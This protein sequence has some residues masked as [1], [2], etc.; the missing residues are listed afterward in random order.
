MAAWKPG[1]S[2]TLASNL[3]SLVLSVLSSA[4]MLF[5]AQLLLGNVSYGIPLLIP[6]IILAVIRESGILWNMLTAFSAIL[7]YYGLYWFLGGHEEMPLAFLLISGVCM[8]GTALITGMI[9]ARERKQLRTHVEQTTQ[10]KLVADINTHLLT[11]ATESELYTLTLRYLYDITQRPSAFYSNGD[12]GLSCV[13]SYPEGLIMYPTELEAAKRAF[14]TNRRVGFG[15]EEFTNSSFLYFPIHS[16][17]AALAVVAILCDPGKPADRNLTQTLEMIFIRV[18]VALDKQRLARK[19]QNA[20]IEKELERIRSD[21]LRAISH[22]FRTPLTGIIGACS[23]LNEEGVELDYHS[24]K[25]LINSIGE[26]AAWLLRMVENLLSVT[27]VGS[28][29][30]KLNKSM[31]PIEELLAETLERTR[32]RFPAVELHMIQP[33]EFLMIP[34][35]PTLI[36]QVLM[37]LIENAVKYSGDKSMVD[38]VVS[39]EDHCVSFL[40][41]DYGKGLAPDKLDHLF[42]PA[43]FR[44][45]D[46]AHGMGLGLSIC[47]SVIVAHGGE[48]E[49]KNGENGGAVFTFTLPKEDV[50]EQQ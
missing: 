33:A 15:T 40:V 34:M 11:A 43:S 24:K 29:G 37:N 14:E 46:S 38:V 6:G 41:R 9:T 8:L 10:D 21:F 45:G 4:L 27:R 49:G 28:S 5:I 26:E 31:E 35:D 12:Q 13:A 50:H 1:I 7:T 18:G 23:A 19:H 25:E 16:D 32:K 44:A 3:S 36:L 42:V 2:K 20:L 30:P 48:I 22:D 39:D 47:R 17:D